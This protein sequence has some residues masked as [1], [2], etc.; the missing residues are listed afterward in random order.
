[1][2][3]VVRIKRRIDEEPLSAFILNSKKRRRLDNVVEE[4]LQAEEGA[5][6]AGEGNDKDG[7]ISTILKFAGTIQEQ[8]NS[9]TTQL[10]RLTK[11]AAKEL[12]LQKSLRTPS[13][14]TERARQEMRQALHESRFRVVNCMRTTLE[15][16]DATE[17]AAKEVTIVDI[18]KQETSGRTSTTATSA[19]GQLDLHQ[20]RE[21]VNSEAQPESQVL[22]SNN[23]QQS[24]DSDTGYVYDLY[25]PDNELQV[26]YADMMDDNYL[27]I[28]PCDGLVY[29][30]HFN[31]DDEEGDSEDSNNENYY[32]NDYP[33]E[34]DDNEDYKDS[35]DHDD[36]DAMALGIRRM[37]V[38]T[39]HDYIHTF[40]GDD[41]SMSEFEESS[42]DVYYDDADYIYGR[43]HVRVHGIGDV[44][45]DGDDTDD[46][47]YYDA[48]G[49]S[50]DSDA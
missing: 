21:A 4:E 42:D 12:V 47:D 16:T 13:N 27:S 9:A 6:A 37:R 26:E 34:D 30:D 32:T 35:Y 33:D 36:I 40:D 15:D 24:T 29:E 8:D 38:G 5:A 43:S 14:H 48:G 1:M 28:R 44:D 19:A 20:Q 23:T 45:S 25:L 11:E 39:D 7:E 18:E 22:A 31:D 49:N 2:P 41:T 10:A 46:V 3:A 17:A 50:D